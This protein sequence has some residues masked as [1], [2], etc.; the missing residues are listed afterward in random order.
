MIRGSSEGKF[1]ACEE[2]KNYAKV[3]GGQI[4]KEHE[5]YHMF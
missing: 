5:K 1:R 3:L 2:C 4:R